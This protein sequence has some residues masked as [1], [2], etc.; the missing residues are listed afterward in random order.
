[1]HP[2]AEPGESAPLPRL[3]LVGGEDVHL[4][5]DFIRRM[6]GL[7]YQVAVAA[8]P[9]PPQTALEAE[10][11]EILR[12][13]LQRSLSLRGD[14][15]A[16]RA[17]RRIVA[18]WRPDIVHAY[19]TKPTYLAPIALIGSP[20]PAVVRTITGMGRI[21]SSRRPGALVLRA[22]HWALHMAARPRVDHTIFQNGTDATYFRRAG[23]AAPARSSLI[24][25]SGIEVEALRRRVSPD[26]RPRLRRELDLAG[27]TVFVMVARLVA[28]KG[29]AEYLEAARRLRET[30][31]DV[32]FLLVGPS[33]GDEPGGVPTATI[34]AAAGHVTYLGR[35]NDVPDLLVASDIFVLPTKYREGVPRAML[36]A[37]ALGR[38]VIVTDMPGCDEA[39]LHGPCGFLARTGDVDSLTAAMHSA[40]NARAELDQLGKHAIDSVKDR[41]S[42]DLVMKETTAI[43]RGLT[44]EAEFK[45]ERS[46]R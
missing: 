24:R 40:L 33:G 20:G 3:L 28:E 17:L 12:Y 23:L 42:M 1:M 45:A 36:E 19:D 37:M 43:Y 18:T 4:R 46:F 44:G 38:P 11:V 16:V 29:V 22:V 2:V 35:R 21:F 26:A 6:R 39:V 13:P 8:P 5:L 14:W 32:A 27:K 25:G 7:G 41:Y 9:D 34:E 30:R 31:D 10:G 15:Q